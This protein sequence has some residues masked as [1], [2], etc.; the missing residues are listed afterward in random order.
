MIGRREVIALLGGV[1]L[2]ASP[3]AAQA[4]QFRRVGILVS[5]AVTDPT[6]VA[7]FITALRKLGWTDGQNLRLY[8]R[9]YDGSPERARA[10]AQELTAIGPMSS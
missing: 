4:Q 7:E 5:S 9:W 3:L 1:G 2:A 8:T 10:F 6:Y